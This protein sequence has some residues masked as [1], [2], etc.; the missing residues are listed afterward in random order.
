V[1][2]EIAAEGNSIASAH[3]STSSLTLC[4]YENKSV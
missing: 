1:R 3:I 4:R 2:Y